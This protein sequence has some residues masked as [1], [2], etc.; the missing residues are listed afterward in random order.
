MKK[1]VLALTAVSALAATAVPAAAQSYGGYDRPYGQDRYERHGG[2]TSINQRQAQLDRRIDQG[3]HRGQLTRGEARSL[4]SEFHA[5]A[6]LEHRYRA[7][8]LSRWE[9]ADLDRRFDA[10]SSRI[11]WE[12]NDRDYSYGYGYRR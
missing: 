7:D 9:R 1:F 2:W 8:G 5:I 12:R 3:V 6:R 4:R 11:R 10:L